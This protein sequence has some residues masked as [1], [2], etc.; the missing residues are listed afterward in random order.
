MALADP[1]ALLES[2]RSHPA[3]TE[4][5]EFKLNNFDPEEIGEYISA[6]ANSAMLHD[7]R[8]AYL[9][10]GVSDGTHELKGTN[11]RL[12]RETVKGDLFEHWLMRMLNPRIN[13]TIE[14]CEIDGKHVEI[15]CIEPAYDR[16]V[17]FLN[18]AYVRVNSVKKRLDEFPEKERT[19]WYLTNRYAFEEGVAAI[20]F[21]GLYAVNTKID[22]AGLPL[23][24]C[25][26]ITGPAEPPVHAIHDRQPLVL[27]PADYDAWLDPATPEA[28][29]FAI[30]GRH[31]NGR[32]EFHR[33][34][35]QVNSN[36][37]QG[38][39]EAIQPV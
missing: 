17:R 24:S 5:F 18:V 9:V 7:K 11:V 19:L 23:K 37:W 4:W 39:S 35:R 27:D 31:I 22:P 20:S 14:E 34:D 15:V 25:T 16:P 2:L 8:H 33:V 36:R 10:F 12:R 26:I 29:L 32:M 30:L 21:A 38:G 28:D 6:L 13:V 1:V 3:E